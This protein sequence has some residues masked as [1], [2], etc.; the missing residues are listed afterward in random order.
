MSYIERNEKAN[1]IGFSWYRWKQVMINPKKLSGPIK[2]S[3]ISRTQC[4]A[5][6]LLLFRKYFNRIPF[7]RFELNSET[8]RDSGVSRANKLQVSF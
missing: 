4:N 2:V 5:M 7:F 1:R 3:V 8:R 6:N